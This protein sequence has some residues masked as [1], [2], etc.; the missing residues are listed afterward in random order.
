[1]RPAPV[2]RQAILTESLN[3]SSRIRATCQSG[4]I[5][6]IRNRKITFA[7]NHQDAAIAL[8]KK[9]GWPTD[10]WVGGFCPKGSP[11]T[12]VFVEVAP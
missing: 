8:A 2:F 5:V 4:S 10:H 1:M 6:V 11:Y 9:L 12:Y 7:Q 3:G